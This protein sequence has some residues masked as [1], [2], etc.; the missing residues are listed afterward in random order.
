ML[1]QSLFR[2]GLQIFVSFG[3]CFVPVGLYAQGAPAP[4][5]SPSRLLEHRYLKSEFELLDGNQDGVISKAEFKQNSQA[6]IEK[7]ER[8]SAKHNYKPHSVSKLYTMNEGASE[9]FPSFSYV[10]TNNDNVIKFHHEYLAFSSR[11]FSEFSRLDRSGDGKITK[12][13][14]LQ[15]KK[16]EFNEQQANAEVKLIEPPQEQR[17]LEFALRDRNKDGVITWKDTLAFNALL[18]SRLHEGTNA[19]ASF[20]QVDANFDGAVSENEFLAHAR[21]SDDKEFL[22]LKQ[23]VFR[24]RDLNQDQQLSFLE[25]LETGENPAR[26]FVTYD[27]D[28]DG[29]IVFKDVEGIQ[30]VNGRNVER[31]RA[32]F[33][34]LDADQDERVT[35][36]EYRTADPRGISFGA[37]DH[38]RIDNTISRD[39][40]NSVEREYRDGQ[41]GKL[42]PVGSA[43]QYATFWF[44]GIFD[45]IT[46]DDLDINKD[47]FI[48]WGEFRKF[49]D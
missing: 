17:E 3:S 48:S 14:Y 16:E 10:D 18:P 8:V 25:F 40:W 2:F 20:V 49:P 44:A 42:L 36:K 5:P 11:V 29:V 24:I 19:D 12:L 27:Q 45:L 46:F 4:Q 30:W 23:K 31:D 38:L 7:A 9:K 32:Y 26:G 33:A 34:R 43:S 37:I 15:S 35:W 1:F 28:G 22:V 41:N 6:A 13:E 21:K 39:E 47:Q